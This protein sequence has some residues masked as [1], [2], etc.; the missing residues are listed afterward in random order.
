MYK[1]GLWTREAGFCVCWLLIYYGCDLHVLRVLMLMLWNRELPTSPQCLCVFVS[2]MGVEVPFLSLFS[3]PVMSTRWSDYLSLFPGLPSCVIV[4]ECVYCTYLCVVM[5][6]LWRS[7]QRPA[8]F[9]CLFIQG[10]KTKFAIALSTSH[11]VGNL[12]FGKVITVR[13]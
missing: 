3:Q 5:P 10:S 11:C 7:S 8:P 13:G 4:Y 9:K 2:H 1:M 12:E 6:C